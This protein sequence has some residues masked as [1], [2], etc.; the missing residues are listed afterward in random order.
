M[1]AQGKEGELG[2]I[3]GLVDYLDRLTDSADSRL[4]HY[5]LGTP[6]T[7]RRW[8]EKLMPTHLLFDPQQSLFAKDSEAPR[9]WQPSAEDGSWV[10]HLWD[11]AGAARPAPWQSFLSVPTGLATEN[12]G[13]RREAPTRPEDLSRPHLLVS[14]P[15]PRSI[16]I[17][18]RRWSTVKAT[19]LSTAAILFT[20]AL[21]WLSSGSL[22]PR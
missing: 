20:A 4:R 16:F 22:G 14:D 9:T 18:D 11:G 19:V 6:F 5:P 12:G 17:S 2:R 1:A 15:F 7:E 10:S 3:R 21:W 13:T 8:W